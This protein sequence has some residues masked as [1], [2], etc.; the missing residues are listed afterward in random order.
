[1][2][3]VLLLAGV[4]AAVALLGGVGS[5]HAVGMF[6]TDEPTDVSAPPNYGQEMCVL[7]TM[8][9]RKIGDRWDVND[10]QVT[11]FPVS[12][13]GKYAH[14]DCT[15]FCAVAAQQLAISRDPNFDWAYSCPNTVAENN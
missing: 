3:R 11:V 15:V 10:E 8:H 1:M 7:R 14:R 4:L 13:G 12:F 5:A 9:W 6:A 2:R